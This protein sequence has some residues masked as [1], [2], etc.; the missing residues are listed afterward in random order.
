MHGNKVRRGDDI[1][2][3]AEPHAE[4]FRALFGQK[5][6]VADHFHAER[7]RPLGDLAA[8]AAHADDA[9][10]FVA[11]FDADERFPVPLAADGFGVGLRNHAR[12]SHDHGKRMFTRRNRIAVRRVDNDNPSLR[13][14]F[15]I[16]VVDADPGAS[17]HLEAGS[18]VHNPFGHFGLAPDEQGVVF[19]DDADQLI[20]G[21][22]GALVHHDISGF[23]QLLDALVADRIRY[24]HFK[25]GT[26]WPPCR[27]SYAVS[28][29][30]GT[31]RRTPRT[32]FSRTPRLSSLR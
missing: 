12:A 13:S 6:I 26:C 18:G 29:E 17:D 3:R 24:E 11:Q 14:R 27:M 23:M 10:H 25:H 7:L 28:S 31:A 16:D 22:T 5:R 1:V 8:D 9:E 15:E 21:Q 20:F 32:V 19:A 30:S 2:D 4:F